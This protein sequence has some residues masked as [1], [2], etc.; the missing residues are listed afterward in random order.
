MFSQKELNLEE[1]QLRERIHALSA[2]ERARYDALE[3]PRLRQASTY[4]LL[5]ALFPFGIHHM[6]LGRWGRALLSLALTTAAILTAIGRAPWDSEPNPLLAFMLM[7]AMVLIE[8]PQM[9]NARLLVQSR[10]N[11]AM[12]QC[13]K[14]CRKLSS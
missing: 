14:Q 6:Y 11:R 1:H 7:L 3:I 2:E 8:V 12:D 13:L 10:N 4:L 5:N 9:M